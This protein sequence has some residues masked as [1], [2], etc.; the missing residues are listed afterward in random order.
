MVSG[1][2]TWLGPS[3]PPGGAF[4]SSRDRAYLNQ[5]PR[6][7]AARRAGRDDLHLRRPPAVE[8]GFT[9]GDIDADEATVSAV[10]LDGEPHDVAQLGFQG[11]SNL[12][13]TTPR[14]SG[15]CSSN[16]TDLP[17]WLPGAATLRGNDAAANTSGASGWFRPTAPVR[18]LTV[19]FRW[20]AGF[21]IYQ[22]WL[23]GQ[24]RTVSGALTGGGCDLEGAPGQPARR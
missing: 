5:S 18:S 10:G 19:A 11:V 2:S 21:R 13:T 20:R 3:S 6:G 1:A 17:T 9:L 15:L 7:N 22:T 23:A 24:T 8:W 4:G 16:P 12:C 14:P